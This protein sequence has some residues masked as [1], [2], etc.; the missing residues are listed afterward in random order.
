MSRYEK[1]INMS[2]DDMANMLA[3]MCKQS[4]SCYDC[5]FEPNCPESEAVSD[6]KEWL[7]SEG[8]P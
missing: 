8:T 3:A 1:I 6:W 7:E 5:L 4:D 2:I